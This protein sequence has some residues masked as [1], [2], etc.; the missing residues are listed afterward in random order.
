MKQKI[1][2]VVVMQ[3]V[4]AGCATEQIEPPVEEKANLPE[5]S[6]PSP[7]SGPTPPVTGTDTASEIQQ[8]QTAIRLKISRYWKRSSTS[9]QD[10][11]CTVRVRL[12]RGGEVMGAKVVRSSGSAAFDRTVLS[13]VRRASPLPLPQN[14]EL[15][16]QFREIEFVFRPEA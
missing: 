10:L 3:F 1:A 16:E 13:A 15:F 7:S 8:A 4:L 11:Q 9:R 5:A 14:P 6:V 2:Y 12:A